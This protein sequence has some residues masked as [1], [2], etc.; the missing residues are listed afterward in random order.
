VKD[1][2]T[3]TLLSRCDSTG[4]LY[5]LRLP[6]SPFSTSTPHALTAATSS[7]TWHCRLGHP[8]RDVMSKLS[9]S[10]VI[11][12]SRGSFG[13]LC[14]ACQLGRHVGLPF[15][16]SSSRAADIFYLVHYDVWTSPLLNVS[17]NKYYLLIMDDY[18][19]YLW[20]SP[21]RLKS[22]T[23]PTLSHFSAWV[24][25]QFGHIVRA[26]QGTTGGSLTTPRPVPSTPTTL[27]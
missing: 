20:T 19:H 5:T 13:H 10:S 26:V 2:A 24:S 12:C 17:G 9:S 23:F 16:S 15:S 21:L 11:P 7:I 4:P 18:S 14:H 25:N 27:S 8:G 1:L 6:A 3:R 22:D